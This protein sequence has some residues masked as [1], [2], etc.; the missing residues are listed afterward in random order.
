MSTTRSLDE[1]SVRGSRFR[2]SNA[3]RRRMCARIG[4]PALRGRQFVVRVT[5]LLGQ[6][7]EGDL[8]FRPTGI[9]LATLL[10]G[11]ASVVATTIEPAPTSVA[12]A[13]ETTTAVTSTSTSTST[14]SNV[15]T[16]LV[17]GA[18]ALDVVAG[19]VVALGRRR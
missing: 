7:T 8:G 15:G 11:P 6:S 4:K 10:L 1:R 19:V 5:L 18:L 9:E 12:S 13:P 16:G 3:Q 14:D 2:G 17:I